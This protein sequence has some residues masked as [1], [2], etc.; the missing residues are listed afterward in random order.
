MGLSTAL[1]EITLVLFTTLAP[2][3][4]FAICALAI[5]LFSPMDDEQR[6]RLDKFTYLPLI[7]TMA[8]LIASATHLGNPSNALFTFMA[9]GTSPLS[10]EVFAAVCFLALAGVYWLCS[11]RP[12]RSRAVRGAWLAAIAV[13]GVAFVCT[14]AFAYNVDS[15]VTWHTPLVPV[16]LVANA[17]VGGPVLAAATLRIARWKREDVYRALG[18]T[19]VAGI[20][21]STAAY[22]LQGVALGSEQNYI[23]EAARL[24]PGYWAMLAG[25]VLFCALGA[26]LSRRARTAKPHA[27]P[28]LAGRDERGRG[29]DGDEG[30]PSEHRRIAGNRPLP[31]DILAMACAFCGIFVMRFAFYMM[32]MTAGMGV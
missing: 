11:F 1:N 7:A 25:Y 21:V 26:L 2:S 14:V 12:L 15:I 31:A 27:V 18:W 5:L 10:N 4:A 20:A 17:C 30:L 6:R 19:C 29:S 22:V 32:H 16:A 23:T 28:S 3:G 13:S 24:V 8:G 9:V